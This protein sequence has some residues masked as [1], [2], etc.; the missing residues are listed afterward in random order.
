MSFQGNLSPAAEGASSRVCCPTF[1]LTSSKRNARMPP[2]LPL[3][4]GTHPGDNGFQ[5]HHLPYCKVHSEVLLALSFPLH[6]IPRHRLPPHACIPLSP[7]TDSGIATSGQPCGRLH[8]R[9]PGAPARALHG[10]FPELKLCAAL[11][12]FCPSFRLLVLTQEEQCSF[13]L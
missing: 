13:S 1:H 11:E 12:S 5:K 6:F 10:V 4:T 7:S 3:H 8:T 9:G 2:A